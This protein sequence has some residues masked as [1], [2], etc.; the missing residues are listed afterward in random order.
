[1]RSN[2]YNSTGQVY[3]VTSTTDGIGATSKVY[4]LYG[5]AFPC[6][7]RQLSAR[8]REMSGSRGVDLSHRLYCDATVNVNEQ[9]EIHIGSTVYRVEV[10]NNVDLTSKHL[11]VDVSERR[12]NRNER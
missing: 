9:D 8:E 4:T 1:M 7:I 12:P 3:R 5:D 6:R 11:Q 2:L 10:V